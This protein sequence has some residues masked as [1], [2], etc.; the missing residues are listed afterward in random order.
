MKPNIANAAIRG[1]LHPPNDLALLTQDMLEVELPNG[2]IIDVG[3]YP[4]HDPNGEYG[5]AVFQDH[6]DKP[7]EKPIYTKNL[8]DAIVA[9]ETIAQRMTRRQASAARVKT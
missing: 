7:L 4:E 9:V 2:V 5:I 6:P 3:W 8:T 1:D